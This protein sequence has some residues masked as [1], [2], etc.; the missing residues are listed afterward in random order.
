MRVRARLLEWDE[1][2]ANN[3]EECP[4]PRLPT[5][6]GL[7]PDV[8]G[9]LVVKQVHVPEAGI[10]YTSYRVAGYSVDPKSIVPVPASPAPR[11]PCFTPD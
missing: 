4:D 9:Q 8:E 2:Q 1:V 10:H 5:Y 3:A 11:A 6:E 7:E